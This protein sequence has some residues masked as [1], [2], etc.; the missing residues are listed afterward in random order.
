MVEFG[1][2]CEA[3]GNLFNM[4]LSEIS[5]DYLN[6]RGF[7]SLHQVLLRIDQKQ[8]LEA[9]LYSLT[10]E[11]LDVLLNHPDAHYR[12]PL[13]WA[14]EF[15]WFEAVRTLLKFGADPSQLTL[16]SRGYSTLLHAAVTGPASQLSQKEY[17]LVIKSLLTAGVDV[18]AKDHEEWTPLHIVASWGVCD[19]DEFFSHPLLD[20]GALTDDGNS[21][22]DLALFKPYSS[23]V[24]PKRLGALA[25]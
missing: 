20:W 10:Q 13:T 1:R 9:Y 5:R 23:I 18:N 21:V 24:F 12:T 11:K 17:R 22:D 16:S 3:I 15:G 19:L 7:T 2:H 25:N 8:S 4:E 14:V 6:S